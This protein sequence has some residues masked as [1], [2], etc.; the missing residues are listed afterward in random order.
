MLRNKAFTMAEA[1]IVLSV[2]GVLAAL[3][4]VAT[5]NSKPD[6]SVIMFRKGYATASKIIQNMMNDTTLYPRAN[7]MRV[8]SKLGSTAY[9]KTGLADTTGTNKNNF[10]YNFALLAN[11]VTSLTGTNCK[12]FTDT[13]IE[14]NCKFTTADGI[15]W[16]V[17]SIMTSSNPNAYI[18]MNLFGSNS[19]GCTYNKDTCPMPTKFILRVNKFGKI[20]PVVS[21]L[22]AFDPVASVYLYYNKINKHSKIPH[23]SRWFTDG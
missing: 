16:E 11:P 12:N 6:E 18:T 2:V 15:Y 5:N 3:S 19:N 13:S 8:S 4:V 22:S 21:N 23:D 20:K 17:S 10:A 7:Q 14:K 9:N 1:L